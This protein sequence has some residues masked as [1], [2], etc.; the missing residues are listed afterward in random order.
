MLAE[1]A[2][3]LGFPVF[4]AG[5]VAA[6]WGC[7]EGKK[8]QMYGQIGII[9]LLAGKVVTEANATVLTSRRPGVIEASHFEGVKCLLLSGT[10]GINVPSG[11][12][13]N[14]AWTAYPAVRFEVLKQLITFGAALAGREQRIAYTSIGLLYQNGLGYVDI[15]SRFLETHPCA[16]QIRELAPEIS[17]FFQGLVAYSQLPRRIAPFVKVL[18]GDLSKMFQPKAIAQLRGLAVEVLGKDDA[19]VAAYNHVP[20]DN[21][22]SILERLE[23][24]ERRQEKRAKERLT[25]I[26]EED[27]QAPSFARQQDESE[28]EDDASDNEGPFAS[29]SA[30]APV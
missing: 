25:S 10:L 18:Y 15:I 17:S 22:V 13:I 9:A 7:T 4:N 20:V 26:P 24:A 16:F 5:K 2:D 21:L 6:L 29:T 11:Y 14:K 1:F 19:T 30:A 28:E 12:M 3:D 8:F 27:T 23:A